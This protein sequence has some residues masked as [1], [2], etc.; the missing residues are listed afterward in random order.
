MS[1]YRLL[2]PTTNPARSGPVLK[3]ISPFLN[4]E[5]SRG[6]LLGVI[7]P[8]SIH[9]TNARLSAGQT[10]ILYTDGVTDAGRPDRPL[11]ASGYAPGVSVEVNR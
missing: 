7:D 9:E 10:L 4:A 1:H 8:I 5:D 2:V 3:A 6:T 11:G